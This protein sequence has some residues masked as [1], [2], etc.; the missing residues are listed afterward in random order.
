MKKLSRHE[1]VKQKDFD[2]ITINTAINYPLVG[3]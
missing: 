1:Y 3:L 2:W